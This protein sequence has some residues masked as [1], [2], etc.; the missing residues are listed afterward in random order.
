MEGEL[1]RVLFFRRRESATFG[2]PR[3]RRRAGAPPLPRRRPPLYTLFLTYIVSDRKAL[4]TKKPKN[5]NNLRVVLGDPRTTKQLGGS[6]GTSTGG[7][8]ADEATG[9]TGRRRLHALAW[10]TTICHIH[11]V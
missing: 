11:S 10:S 6:R 7:T 9:K 4:S 3:R 5:L 8:H 1:C 2:V